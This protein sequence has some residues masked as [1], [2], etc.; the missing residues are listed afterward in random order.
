[1][2]K[3]R[4]IIV[5]T[6]EAVRV[7]VVIECAAGT[8]LYDRHDFSGGEKAAMDKGFAHLAQ[9]AAHRLTRDDA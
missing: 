6:T 2:S 9:R 8:A 1:M 4:P 3:R 7:L 5:D